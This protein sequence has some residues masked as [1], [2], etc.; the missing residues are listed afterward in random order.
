MH[1][2]LWNPPPCVHFRRRPSVLLHPGHLGVEVDAHPLQLLVVHAVHVHRDVPIPRQRVHPLPV[3]PL[4]V[5]D[6]KLLHMRRHV[7]PR[8]SLLCDIALCSASL[9]ASTDPACLCVCN[10]DDEPA[11]HLLGNRL[12]NARH[13]RDLPC[14][15]GP[16]TGH[17]HQLYPRPHVLIRLL[18]AFGGPVQ[19]IPHVRRHH[20]Y[21]RPFLPGHIVRPGVPHP[22]RPPH[23]PIQHLLALHGLRRLILG[24]VL[25]QTERN[26]ALLPRRLQRSR[27]LHAHLA[28]RHA[29]LRQT[30]QVERLAIR[31]LA[32][33]FRV[34]RHRIHGKQ[35]EVHDLE[36]PRGRRWTAIAIAIAIASP[37]LHA[38]DKLLLR[39]HHAGQRRIQQPHPPRPARPVERRL[40]EPTGLLAHI[41][42]QNPRR[43]ILLRSLPPVRR[44][45]LPDEPHILQ[46]KLVT[47][48]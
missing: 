19:S 37:P 31:V 4:H 3:E 20:V 10:L 22:R 46:H 18:V 7:S 43:V 40:E 21:N 42:K 28:P 2:L 25:H 41:Q 15:L 32:V 47:V 13:V 35:V 17:L 1:L 44:A 16:P 30:H 48:I 39:V 29:L 6:R 27:D 14:H 45:V 38:A 11:P 8:Q 34:R 5:P 36:L 9:T 24:R 12:H 26:R 33:A 23:H